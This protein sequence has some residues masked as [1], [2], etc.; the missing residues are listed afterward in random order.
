LATLNAHDGVVCFCGCCR[1]YFCV[2]KV[3]NNLL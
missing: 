1:C 2:W 3:Y